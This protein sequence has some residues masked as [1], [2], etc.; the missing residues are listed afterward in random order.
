MDEKGFAKFSFDKPLEDG[1]YTVIISLDNYTSVEFEISLSYDEEDHKLDYIGDLTYIELEK[2][3]PPP[4]PPVEFF[5]GPINGEEGVIQGAEVEL[6]LNDETIKT[7]Y[8]DDTGYA[9]FSFDTPP[10]DGTYDL[11]I[12]YE[13]YENL[14]INIILNYNEELHVL[15]V[16]G[17]IT[18]ITLEKIIPP[19]PVDDQDRQR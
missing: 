1:I 11:T 17:D 9:K 3:I 6:V 5:V 12:T 4:L 10:E 13:G 19:E 7:V 14:E 15:S 16:A 8:T 18:D 2:L